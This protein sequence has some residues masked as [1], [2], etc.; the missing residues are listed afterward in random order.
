MEVFR[1]KFSRTNSSG[2]EISVSFDVS[3][4]GDQDPFEL[5]SPLDDFLEYC[6]WNQEEREHI[7]K[8]LRDW[9]EKEDDDDSP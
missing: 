1:Y 5:Y 9:N 4:E 7:G 6:G 3:G 8:G 2:D